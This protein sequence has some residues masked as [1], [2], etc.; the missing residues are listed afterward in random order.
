MTKHETYELLKDV[1][2]IRT[3][4]K[5]INIKNHSFDALPS[6]IRFTWKHE[7]KGAA[8][9]VNVAHGFLDNVY[10]FNIDLDNKTI[11]GSGAYSKDWKYNTSNKMGAFAT[12]LYKVAEQAA[13]N[14]EATEHTVITFDDKHNKAQEDAKQQETEQKAI[15]ILHE[16]RKMLYDLMVAES[17]DKIMRMYLAVSLK[18]IGAMI[19]AQH[20][21]N[22]LI[23]QTKS[24]R[25]QKSR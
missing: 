16:V 17:N 19:A 1:M 14:Q 4:I 15:S 13:A 21:S 23:A 7:F 2:N 25:N 11:V 18:M 20:A 6:A 5:K 10:W 22:R 3:P 8:Y 9:D 12:K 24:V